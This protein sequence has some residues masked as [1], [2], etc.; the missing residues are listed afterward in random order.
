MIAAGILDN[1]AR[2]LTDWI[3]DTQKFKPGNKMVLAA[4]SDSDVADIVAYLQSL[5]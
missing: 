2:D 1:T 4:P 5:R 3:K